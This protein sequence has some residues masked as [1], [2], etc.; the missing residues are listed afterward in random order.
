MRAQQSWRAVADLLAS[1]MANHAHCA[2]HPKRDADVQN[3]PFCAD[4]DA[5]LKWQDKKRSAS[6]GVVDG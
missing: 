2:A 6:G 4:R 5:Y 3:C 1:R